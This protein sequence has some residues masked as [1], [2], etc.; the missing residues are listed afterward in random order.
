MN[1]S[2]A[3]YLAS[4]WLLDA[5]NISQQ[6]TALCFIRIPFMRCIGTQSW[7][8]SGHGHEIRDAQ[9]LDRYVN[10]FTITLL[11]AVGLETLSSVVFNV[12]RGSVCLDKLRWI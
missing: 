2:R 11:A 8:A 12:E 5:T 3:H 6:K 7:I 1:E 4:M 9:H 10:E